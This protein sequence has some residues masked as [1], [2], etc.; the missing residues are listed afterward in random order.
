[1]KVSFLY[2]TEPDGSF[3]EV[4]R[5][6]VSAL[7]DAGIQIKFLGTWS[8]IY[9]HGYGENPFD[10]LVEQSYQ[11]SRIYVILGHNFE[12]LG[13]MIS[14]QK[15]GLLDNGEYF[16]IGVDIEQYDNQNP[17]K[18]LKGLLKDEIE[19][20]SKKAFQSYLGVVAS[21]P[22]GFEDFTAK[23]NKYM[24]LPPFNFPNPVSSFGGMKKVPAEGAYLYDAVYVYARALNECLINKEDPYDGREIMK[25]ITGTTYFSEIFSLHFII[26]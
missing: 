17:M 23:V 4:S 26:V 5:T 25:Y 8:Y 14:L 12:Y 9:H 20:D 13:M 15:R 7:D 22:I 11:E 3:R 18:Y 21:P 10:R 2:S 19:A 1:M 24:Q 16:V 6:I